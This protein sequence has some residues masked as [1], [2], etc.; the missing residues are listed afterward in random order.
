LVKRKHSAEVE[1]AA[2]LAHLHDFIMSLPDG[3]ETMVGERGVKLSG[4]EKAAGIDC[5]GSD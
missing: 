2:R 1:H 5:A 4:G 3:Y